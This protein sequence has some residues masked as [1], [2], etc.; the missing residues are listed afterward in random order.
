MDH[1]LHF[2][3]GSTSKVFFSSSV[4]VLLLLSL[5]LALARVVYK[6]W[7][8]PIRIQRMMA[9]QGIKGP[10]YRFLHGNTKEILT[11]RKE[12]MERPMASHLSHDILPRLQPNIHTWVDTYGPNY[13]YWFGPQPQLVVTEPEMIKEVL[14]NKD[15]NYRKIKIRGFVKMLLGDGLVTSAGEK[16]VK[17]RKLA[18]HAFHGES[19]KSS[20]PAVV[21]SVHMMLE[22]WK[23]HEG[24]EIEFFEEFIFLTS[25]VISRTAFGSSYVEGRN[26]FEMLRGLAV[27][28][29]RNAFK[30][31]LPGISKIWKTADEIEGEKLEKGIRDAILRIIKKR[32]EKIA[33]GELDGYGNDFLGLLMQAFLEEDRKKRITI[34][35]V[36]DECKTFY[37]A[38]QE[39]TNTMLT[40][41]LF[42]LAVYTDWQEEARKE[43]L[44]VFGQRDPYHDG[45]TKLKTMTMIINESLRLYTPVIS[46][47]RE[48]SRQDRLGKLVV[49][50]NMHILVANLKVH[51]DPQIWGEDAHLFK[52]ERFS[53][54]VAKAT[55][56]NPAVFLPFGMG[57]RN[58]VGMNF[59][60]T[61]AKIAISMILQRY[62]FTLSP[63]YV[64]SPT[65]ILTTRP[66]HGVHVILHPLHKEE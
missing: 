23:D 14:N 36:V 66:Q 41:T 4:L 62:S 24:K 11:M 33:Y 49:P 43:V 35:D 51:H 18:N 53:E 55:N 38:G 46:L 27:L 34:D 9:A 28:T 32:E 12:A 2:L 25:E 17:Q 57:P 64:H 3:M 65:Q 40:W 37:V 6:L 19:L 39:T 52:P 42:L 29:S 26:I 13:L 7:L 20:F 16:W 56:N 59:A 45:I 21:D 31:R 50:A 8:N 22:K 48:V 60:I 10:S 15:K 5:C 1:S 63:A 47:T 30:L 44:Y 61:E 54:G 58:C